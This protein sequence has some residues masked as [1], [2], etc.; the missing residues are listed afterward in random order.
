MVRRIG[1]TMIDD[2]F[3]D[4]GNRKSNEELAEEYHERLRSLASALP[5]WLLVDRETLQERIITD[6]LATYRK[7]PAPQKSKG[8]KTGLDFLGLL[9]TEGSDNG[10]YEFTMEQLE[11]E[12]YQAVSKLPDDEIIALLLPM[13]EDIEDLFTDREII[14]WPHFLLRETDWQ[15]KM[16]K[17]LLNQVKPK[18]RY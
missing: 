11:S 18:D 10:L 15:E 16:R 2:I 1:K 13:E 12:I 4:I 6:I 3:Q 17:L 9:L 14:E 7:L 8:I 5:D